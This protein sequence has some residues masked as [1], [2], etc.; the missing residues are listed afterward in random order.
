LVDDVM[1][2][3]RNGLGERRN[4]YTLGRVV[5]VLSSTA[6]PVPMLQEQT[7]GRSQLDNRENTQL[8]RISVP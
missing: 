7:G 4:L 8:L 1:K 3:K 2:R 6:V 5:L